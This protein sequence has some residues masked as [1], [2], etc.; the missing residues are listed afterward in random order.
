MPESTYSGMSCEELQEQ[1]DG[2]IPIVTGGYQPYWRVSALVNI[3]LISFAAADIPANGLMKACIMVIFD[4]VKTDRSEV[5]RQWA[6]YMIEFGA[7]HATKDDAPPMPELRD[8]RRD[9]PVHVQ[10]FNFLKGD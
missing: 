10:T 1:L 4:A 9:V 5:V 8:Y 7:G 6:K 3:G 2:L